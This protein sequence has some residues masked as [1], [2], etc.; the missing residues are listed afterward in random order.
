MNYL[1]KTFVYKIWKKFFYNRWHNNYRNKL[2][3]KA[4][5]KGKS[6][7]LDKD[8]IFKSSKLRLNL[9]LPLYKTDLIQQTILV[10]DD[11]YEEKLLNY[12]FFKWND[13]ILSKEL[14][15]NYFC[16][17]G[18]NIGN[19]SLYFFKK[20]NAK[21]S[22]IFEPVKDT[23]DTMKKNMEINNYLEVSK[24]YNVGLCDKITKGSVSSYDLS[25]TGG[26]TLE[27]SEKGELQLI[28]ID[29][30]EIKEP[31]V[32]IKIDTEGF[33]KKVVDGAIKTIKKH[34]PYIMIEV[35]EEN[36]EYI[37][38][39]LEKIGYKYESYDSTNFLFYVSD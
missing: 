28:T 33:E 17:I 26:T 39:K 6:I 24:L 27:T 16:D 30:L 31:L 9:Y 32:L 11:Y 10:K 2:K 25:N 20:C 4:I 13:G 23:F 37:Y 5:E 34:K 29:S 19:H 1:R 36:F 22:Y 15:E 18:S 3:N 38:S 35:Q 14:K 21:G 7:N 8:Y 12:F